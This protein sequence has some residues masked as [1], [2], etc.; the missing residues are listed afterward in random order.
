MLDLNRK[1]PGRGEFTQ[2]M[3][4]KLLHIEIN[5]DLTNGHQIVEKAS[6]Q[7]RPEVAQKEWS[8]QEHDGETLVRRYAVEFDSG[9]A[10]VE[11][12]EERPA[13][14]VRAAQD[15]AG[16]NLCRLWFHAGVAG[17]ARSAAQR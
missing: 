16:P 10:T 17:S 12:R 1:K 4:G 6:L 2:E 9:K 13:T 11:A 14:P 15:R 7:Q 3:Q 8:W 5:Y